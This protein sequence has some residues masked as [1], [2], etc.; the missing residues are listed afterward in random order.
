MVKGLFPGL[1]CSF[2]LPALLGW[3]RLP[4][5]GALKFLG[6]VWYL[7]LYCYFLGRSFPSFGCL[8]ICINSMQSLFVFCYVSL[9]VFASGVWATFAGL[10]DPSLRELASRLE[11][12][13]I[14]SRATG[15][16]DAY[17]RAFLRWR[18]FAASS[19]LSQSMWSCTF[20]MS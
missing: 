8:Y 19:L 9:D 14:A 3:C 12:T 2:R 4:F 7:R 1:S 17:R 15:T 20:S 11:S 13:V 10:R 18:S 6:F 5:L 16:T